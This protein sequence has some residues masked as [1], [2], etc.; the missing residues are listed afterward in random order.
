MTNKVVIATTTFSPTFDLRATLALKTAENAKAYGYRL[1]VVDDGSAEEL[2]TGL[3]LRRADLFDAAVRHQPYMCMGPGR[4]Q[5]MKIAGEIAG[6]NGLVLWMEPEKYTL[7]S[8]IEKMAKPVFSFSPF[9]GAADMVIPD[10]GPLDSYPIEQRLAEPLGN[11]AFERLTGLKLDMWSG[12]K[13]MNSR[14]LQ[15]FLSYDGEYGDRWDSVAIPVLQA[16]AAGLK[17]VGVRVNYVHPPEQTVGEETVEMLEK[18]IVQLHNLVP[19]MIAEAKKL[20]LYP[21]QR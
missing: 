10:R 4:R 11:L 17:V 5:A 1:V 19:A 8:E 2:R 13:A 18:R 16:I 20:G 9:S 14:A 12:P 21:K 7:I 3:R 15:Y 6:E